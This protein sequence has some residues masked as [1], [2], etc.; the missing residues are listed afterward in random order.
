MRLFI[1]IHIILLFMTDPNINPLF[2]KHQ[3][4]GYTGLINL[5][6]TCFLN[7][8]LQVLNHTYE[9]VDFIYSDKIQKLLKHD[10][11]DSV[12]I[13]EW[14]DLRQVMWENNGI[15][16]PNKFVH[17]VHKLAQHK[18]KDIFTGWAQNDLP[19]F[20]FFVIDCIHNSISR[21]IHMKIQGDPQ[22]KLDRLAIECYSMLKKIYDTDYSEIMEMFYGI[23]ISQ[24]TSIDGE[25]LH[26]IKP[27]HYFILDLPIPENAESCSIYDC[28]D[29]MCK[30]EILKDEN[31]WYNEKTQCKEDIQKQIVFWNFPNILIIT[32]KRFSYD[33]STKMNTFV[34]FSQDLDLSKYVAGYNASSYQYE[35]FGVCNHVGNVMGGHYTSFVK[36][37]TN[38]WI[39][40]NDSNVDIMK[41]TQNIESPMAYCLFYRKKNKSL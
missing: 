14:A 7:S 17:Y 31:A 28:F 39:H 25:V 10:C 21:P 11:S 9:L 18:E 29:T 8:C 20:L 24:I 1:A 41:N 26:T 32:L 6:N 3:N 15:V 4:K 30:V 35:L 2:T 13:I 34:H 5:G 16:S 37:A 33:G 40:Y 27:E 36:N 22:N 23:Y 19:E 12:I 38:E